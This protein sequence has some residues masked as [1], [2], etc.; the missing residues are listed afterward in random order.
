MTFVGDEAACDALA[1]GTAY[2]DTARLLSSLRDNESKCRITLWAD[3]AAAGPN[4]ADDQTRRAPA[5]FEAIIGDVFP[6]NSDSSTS[7]SFSV[8]LQLEIASWQFTQLQTRQGFNRLKWSSE[9]HVSR[10]LRGNW[11]LYDL[12]PLTTRLG[13]PPHLLK[14]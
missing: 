2:R 9:E 5:A 12:T 6:N 13:M 8:A 10:H 1:A 14:L 7:F 4:P 11:R 3:R